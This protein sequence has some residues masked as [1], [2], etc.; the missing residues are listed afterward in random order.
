MISQ[1]FGMFILLYMYNMFSYVINTDI[2]TGE[3]SY[4]RSLALSGGISL[5]LWAS[6]FTSRAFGL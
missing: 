3:Y 6:G 4:K 2:L 1:L 5:F